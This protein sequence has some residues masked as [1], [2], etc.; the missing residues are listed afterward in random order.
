MDKIK[1][2]LYNLLNKEKEK[3]EKLKQTLDKLK[4]K[5]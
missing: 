5:R 3:G 2:K 4:N 1:D